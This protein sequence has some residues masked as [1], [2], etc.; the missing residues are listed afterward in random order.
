VTGLARPDF[1]T[2]NEFR[3]RHLE[4]LADLFVQVLGLCRRAG[5]VR[6][7]HVALDGSK[8]KA[9]ASKHK[10]MSYSRMVAAEA[11]LAAEVAG[12]LRAAEVQ[13]RAEDAEHG[14]ERRGDEPPDWMRDKQ[15]RPERIRAAKAALEAEAKAAAAAK[16]AMPKRH[17]GGRKPKHPPGQPKPQAQRNFTD[18]DCCIMVGK[19]GFIQAYNAQIAATPAPRV[20]RAP[21]H[22]EVSLEVAVSGMTRVV[23]A[24]STKEAARY[25]KSLA[26]RR[27]ERLQ[28]WL[29]ENAGPDMLS[30]RPKYRANDESHQGHSA[31]AP[32]WLAMALTGIL[33]LIRN[34]ASRSLATNFYDSSVAHHYSAM[35]RI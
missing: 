24:D 16:A 2:V 3:K 20:A 15:R 23:G 10:A 17:R 8:I 18:P 21:R 27:V 9:N 6:L 12:W 22:Y 30:I 28:Q 35:L 31:V 33:R 7:G 29:F 13:D 19:D 5:L 34:T 32:G 1:R 26:G 14:P 25:N 4:A 11:S